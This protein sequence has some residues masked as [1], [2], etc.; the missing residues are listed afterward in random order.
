MRAYCL[1]FKMALEP[2]VLSPSWSSHARLS[3]MVVLRVVLPVKLL[4]Q[5]KVREDV[6]AVTF[7]HL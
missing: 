1:G 6:A 7:H 4:V 3:H 2:H 5:R